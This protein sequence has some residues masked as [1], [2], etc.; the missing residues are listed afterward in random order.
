MKIPD[1]NLIAAQLLSVQ[2]MKDDTFSK[3]LENS[4]SESELIADGYEPVSNISLLW[5]KVLKK[6]S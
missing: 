2:P 6:R 1:P 4:R 3:L 5:V